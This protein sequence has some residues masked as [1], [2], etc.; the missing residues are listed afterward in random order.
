MK[1]LVVDDHPLVREGLKVAL[2][3]AQ[4]DCS[5]EEAGSAA[6]AI[7]YGS[8][9]FDLILLDLSL[10]DTDR[11]DPTAIVTRVIEA[12]PG[13]PIIVVS[14]DEDPSR[15]WQ[16]M[17][18]GACGYF[19]K[20]MPPESLMPAVRCVLA[21]GIY[22]PASAVRALEPLAHGEPAAYRPGTDPLF[23]GLTERQTQVALLAAQ[24]KPF[25]VIARELGISDGTVKSHLSAVYKAL[26][27][28]SREQLIIML[29]RQRYSRQP[30]P[31][32]WR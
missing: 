15:I 1:I 26:G 23:E 8:V 25:K 29:E 32:T 7:E 14:A 6:E 16:A 4:A 17:Q 28:A 31:Q 18:A 5:I 13:V 9:S 22:L 21:R 10:R 19:P 27:I 12:H 11:R 24:A 20:S 3:T 30:G 2:R